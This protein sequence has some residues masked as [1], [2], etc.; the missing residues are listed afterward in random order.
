MCVSAS[1]RLPRCSSCC[2][3]PGQSTANSGGHGVT[4][5]LADQLG[6]SLAARGPV[7]L[8]DRTSSATISPTPKSN[9]GWPTAKT[10]PRCCTACPAGVPFFARSTADN[11]RP[12]RARRQCSPGTAGAFSDSLRKG[13]TV[14]VVVTVTLPYYPVCTDKWSPLTSTWPWSAPASLRRRGE[15]RRGQVSDP[16]HHGLLEEHPSAP[17][18][19]PHFGIST[20]AVCR[21]YTGPSGQLHGL[22]RVPALPCDRIVSGPG[23]QATAGGGRIRMGCQRRLNLGHFRRWKSEQF[24][25]YAG[26]CSVVVLM[27]GRVSMPALRSR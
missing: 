12:T 11:R 17:G 22:G 10:S 15:L 13:F 14:P 20:V 3:C 19:T 8:V 16:G 18:R 25:V 6:A 2:R 21:C 27:L 26:G 23:Q 1:A 24:R 5:V 4:S 7:R 9:A